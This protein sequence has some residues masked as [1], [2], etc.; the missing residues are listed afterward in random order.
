[1]VC[2]TVFSAFMESICLWKNNRS[3]ERRSAASA[4]IP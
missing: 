4:E 2:V 3:N 1:M